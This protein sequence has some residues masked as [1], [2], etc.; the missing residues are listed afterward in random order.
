[1]SLS[2]RY[3]KS[4]VVLAVR[5]E[6]DDVGRS[7]RALLSYYQLV[8]MLGAKGLHV[9]MIFQVGI[10]AVDMCLKID[11]IDG[12]TLNPIIVAVTALLPSPL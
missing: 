5:G 11:Y 10:G 8:A 12:D 1:V 2:G 6:V 4:A 9:R 7:A 3:G